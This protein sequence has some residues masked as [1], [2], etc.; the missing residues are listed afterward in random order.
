VRDR[1]PGILA[2]D[3]VGVGDLF[4]VVGDLNQA[5]ASG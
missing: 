3:F 2:V 5:L 1:Q 4:A